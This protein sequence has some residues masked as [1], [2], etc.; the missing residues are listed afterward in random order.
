MPQMG[1][2]V[3]EATVVDVLVAVG[4]QV[5]ADVPLL[6]L[7]TDKAT[8]EVTAP[9]DGYVTAID[10]TVGQV[11]PIGARLAA[12]G[13]TADEEDTGPAQSA[14]AATAASAS[15]PIEPATAD[16]E[17]RNTRTTEASA[18]TSA[19]RLRVA[20]VARRAALRMG[21]ELEQLQGTGPRGRITLRD[22]EA[23][24]ARASQPRNGTSGASAAPVPV[25]SPVVGGGELEALSGMRRVIARR[26][27]ASQLIPQYRLERDVDASHLLA[28]KAAQ[29]AAATGGARP[30]V[31]DLLM[32]AIAEMVVR[33]PTLATIY[34]DGPEPGLGRHPDI[35]VGL[36]VATDRGLV[37]PVLHAVD[38]SGLRAIAAERA[39]LVATAREGRLSLEQMSGGAIT[40][41]N[42]GSFGIDRFTAMLNPGESAIVAV[43]RVI[44]RVMPRGRGLIVAPMVTVTMTFDHRTVDGATGA[45]ALA[46]LAELLEGG[47]TWRP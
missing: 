37:V 7:E 15:E 40:L 21:I 29:A 12:I 8:I 1:L 13:D 10:V 46:D 22:V 26:M 24:A 27:T 43:G 32:Q 41:S 36:A 19:G 35:A 3:T 17:I 28:E 47:M 42:L 2:E 25:T 31:N 34:V 4:E 9:H 14:T 30:G 16:T 5:A 18:A 6:E 23:A 20:P 11:V 33:N 39:K 45:A 38:Q 44:D